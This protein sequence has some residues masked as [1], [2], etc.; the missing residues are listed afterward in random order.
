[1]HAAF[2]FGFFPPPSLV[3]TMLIYLATLQ[4]GSFAARELN[5]A[6][7]VG[8]PS[9]LT[10]S[11]AIRH[12]GLSC[13]KRNEY[14]ICLIVLYR[15]V[16]GERGGGR[17]GIR[18]RKTGAE[19]W[20]VEISWKREACLYGRYCPSSS[21]PSTCRYEKDGLHA[22]ERE[23][24]F[25][26]GLGLPDAGRDVHLP[27]LSQLWTSQLVHM[28]LYQGWDDMQAGLPLLSW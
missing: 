26:E 15:W 27:Q 21:C 18:M 28:P 13:R 10:S 5:G 14:C 6:S 9:S 7:S 12:Q 11:Q 24:P 17:P 22:W 20:E 8:A 1:M 16:T 25:W 19:S 4:F 3:T 2:T 23:T